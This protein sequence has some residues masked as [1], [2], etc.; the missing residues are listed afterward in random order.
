MA[1]GQ[2]HPQTQVKKF[3]PNIS[4]EAGMG[5]MPPHEPVVPTA[6]STIVLVCSGKPEV[7]ATLS[8]VGCR[9]LSITIALM[10][11]LPGLL[12]PA[13]PFTS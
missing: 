5:Q 12:W 8:V 7:I 9:C 6:M 1:R 11:R 10:D 13:L 4:D 2:L 3:H